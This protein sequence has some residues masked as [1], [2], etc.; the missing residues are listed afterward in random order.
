MPTQAE[1]SRPLRKAALFPTAAIS[2]VA[3]IGLI[4]GTE[5]SRRIWLD[6]PIACHR[7]ILICLGYSAQPL[8]E[9]TLR[10]IILKH[11]DK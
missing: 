10:Q 5:S 8:H 6:D 2:A 9:R 3:V 7:Y 11:Y 1:K 4:P